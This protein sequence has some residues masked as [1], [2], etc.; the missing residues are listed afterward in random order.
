MSGIPAEILSFENN[1]VYF[2]YLTNLINTKNQWTRFDFGMSL[3]ET[4]RYAP[5]LGGQYASGVIL[6]SYLFE[7]F[8]LLVF[9]GIILMCICRCCGRCGGKI[10]NY[11]RRPALKICLVGFLIFGTICFLVAAG[12][13]LVGVTM[14]NVYGNNSVDL[15]TQS[16]QT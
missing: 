9:G 16:H 14:F 13:G 12:I 3:V 5:E 7:Y 15:A 2:G 10:V 11:R 1:S 4:N 8:G 6:M